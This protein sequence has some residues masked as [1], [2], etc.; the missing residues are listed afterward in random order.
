MTAISL[1][2]RPNSISRLEVSRNYLA[3]ALSV[4]VLATGAIPV[5]S[6]AEGLDHE[7]FD[8]DPGWDAH[9]NQLSPPA[10][11]TA[12]QDFGY[13]T[14]NHAGSAAGEIGGIVDRSP[15][16]P[17][18]YAQVTTPLTFDDPLSF[19]GQISLLSASATSGFT[20]ASNIFIGFFN[21]EEQGWRPPNWLGFQ[22]QGFNEPVPNVATLEL[23]YGTSA[24]EADGTIWGQ[25]VFPNGAQH[26]FN[27]TYDPNNGSGRITLAWNGTEIIA[28][29][30][31]S[32]HRASGA[33]FNRFGIFNME[34]PGVPE[35]NTTEVYFD[36][37]TVNGAL[38]DFATDPGWEGVGNQT[39]F[40]DSN[41]Y[42]I[43]NF[44]YRTTSFAGGSPGELGGW[45]GAWKIRTNSSKPTMRRT[46][47]YLV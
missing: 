41:L 34:L 13:R 3:I 14:S 32:E 2:K 11:R 31:R 38:H 30:V 27:L 7:N 8:S 47:E 23:S 43:N 44:G 19:S 1:I 29:G 35:G 42:G 21:S 17:A 28:L 15:L 33:T 9:N 12:T 24:W 10:P 5:A 46:S 39:T 36:D 26:S 6:L 37:L 18:W 4:F 16:D 25:T 22:V 45:H 40:S 20:S